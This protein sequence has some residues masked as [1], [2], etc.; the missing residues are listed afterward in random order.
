MLGAS[1][2]P[3]AAQ[4]LLP[5]GSLLVGAT[6]YDLPPNRKGTAP[7]AAIRME[8]PILFL[9]AEGSLGLFRFH[10]PNERRRIYVVDEAQIQYQFLPVAIKPY[11]G[12][13]IGRFIAIAGDSPRRGDVTLSAAAGIRVGLP[14]VGA[15]LRSEF[16]V[17]YV[18]AE[19]IGSAAEWT[20]G[21]SW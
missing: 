5:S 12:A 6:N 10:P 20:V 4:Y 15:R 9:V 18:G 16:R 17:R 3:A 14:A 7:F 21:V 8:Y 1:P 2:A 11:F 19:F 13:G